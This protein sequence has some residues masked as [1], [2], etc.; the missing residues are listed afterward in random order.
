VE[1][2]PYGNIAF[3]R[4]LLFAFSIEAIQNGR[5][6]GGMRSGA[7]CRRKQFSGHSAVKCSPV[8]LKQQP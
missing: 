4:P 8:G 6:I 1:I 2:D 5:R 7:K 3:G